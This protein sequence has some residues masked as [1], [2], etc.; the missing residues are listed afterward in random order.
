MRGSLII[1]GAIMP[2]A[3]M[4]AALIGLTATAEP[5]AAITVELANKCR[6]MAIKSHPPP[7]P[8]G[9]Q[10]Y[11]A[12]ERSVFQECVKNNGEMKNDRSPQD[13]AAPKDPGDHN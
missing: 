11:A 8:P 2:T 5:A 4:L 6:Q 10:A 3:V 7:T 13:N 12:A 9:N 1:S